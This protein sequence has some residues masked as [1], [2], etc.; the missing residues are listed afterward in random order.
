[1]ISHDPLL[2]GKPDITYSSNRVHKY[3]GAVHVPFNERLYDA[4]CPCD[5]VQC[6]GVTL[7]STSGAELASMDIVASSYLLLTF[8]D[9]QQVARDARD[10]RGIFI[11]ARVL[12]GVESECDP[13]LS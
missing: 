5:P 3:Q 6:D 12:R 9:E 7:W 2:A 1:M 13:C 8:L 10:H 11:R 4:G